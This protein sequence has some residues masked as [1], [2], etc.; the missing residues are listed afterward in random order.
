ML[1]FT[2]IKDWPL[3]SQVCLTMPFKVPE[4]GVFCH[5]E[6]LRNSP[7]RLKLLLS[8]SAH[9]EVRACAARGAITPHGAK[10]G[11]RSGGAS[12]RYA[13]SAPIR[14]ERWSEW[15]NYTET[16]RAYTTICFTIYIT[17]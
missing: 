9:D 5:T 13:L 8:D 3:G 4:W 11:E 17:V 12:L 16:I 14:G 15:S 7:L 2:R 10:G 6:K 1:S